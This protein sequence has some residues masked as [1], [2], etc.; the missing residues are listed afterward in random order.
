[1]SWIVVLAP[2]GILLLSLFIFSEVV[3]LK[4]ER[5]FVPHEVSN[6]QAVHLIRVGKVHDEAHIALGK[7]RGNVERKPAGGE[8]EYLVIFPVGTREFAV[9][10]YARHYHLPDGIIL[11]YYNKER[12][13]TLMCI[14][15]LPDEEEKVA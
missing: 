3:R 9:T 5:Q 8:P 6:A 14:G 13:S 15:K 7:V 11:V 12:Q 10:P 2:F 1:M 4:K